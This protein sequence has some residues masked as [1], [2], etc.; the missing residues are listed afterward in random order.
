M[1]FQ[2]QPDTRRTPD[3]IGL[4]PMEFQFQ[5]NTCGVAR[6]YRLRAGWYYYFDVKSTVINVE[7]SA[8]AAAVIYAVRFLFELSAIAVPPA[9]LPF[10]CT[11]FVFTF[12]PAR[13]NASS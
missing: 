11:M 3:S 6:Y 2:F 8:L 9:V 13:F 7:P 12:N 10:C 1:G 5:P 4:L